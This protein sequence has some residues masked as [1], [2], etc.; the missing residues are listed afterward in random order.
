MENMKCTQ[1]PFERYSWI[2]FSK[3]V[4]GGIGAETVKEKYL[5]VW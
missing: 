2:W 3:N 4:L 5:T 1:F